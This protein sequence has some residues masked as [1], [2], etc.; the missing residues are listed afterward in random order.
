[1]P[2]PERSG[3]KG[4]GLALEWYCGA[5]SRQL[6][7]FVH[8]LSKNLRTE[9]PE[10]SPFIEP[11]YAEAVQ[12]LPAGAIWTYEA[13]LDGYRCL[14]AKSGKNVSLWSRR[15]NSFNARFPAISRACQNFPP[16]T[17]IDGEVIAIDSD[18]RLS[19]NA[20]QHSAATAHIQFYA[21]DVLRYRGR[22]VL[23]LPL[24]QRR[25]LLADALA[26]IEYP[27]L[28]STPFDADPV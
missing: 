4:T 6:F 13:K 7:F 1:M 27:V 18:G 21:F 25:E 3:V 16:D 10:P 19:F 15:G 2:E 9:H 12:E 14:A 17:L 28:C 11:T 22:D 5:G 8:M 23:R 20:L 24:E 26:K